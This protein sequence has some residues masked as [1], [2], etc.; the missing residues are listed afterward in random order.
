VL[1][2]FLIRVLGFTGA[3]IG[4]VFAVGGGGSLLGA[5]LAGRVARRVGIG[6]TIIFGNFLWGIG[7]LIIPVAGLVGGDVLLIAAG[8]AI[9][10]IGA[11]IWGVNQMSLRQSIT[12]VGLFARA[13]AARRVLMFS[14]QIMGAAL[15]GLLG[16]AVG[17]RTTLVIGAAGLVVGF[18]IVLLS[19]VRTVR[20]I[21]EV[22]IN[23]WPNHRYQT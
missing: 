13:T 2:L 21:S 17:L 9:A 10:N 8:Q 18:L 23:R 22:A 12:P 14:M 6:P 1:V 5:L 7:V 16:G 19:P 20:D 4:L 3:E 15:G 11:T